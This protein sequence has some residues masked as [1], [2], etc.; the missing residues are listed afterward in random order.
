MKKLFLFIYVVLSAF[1]A[2]C[3]DTLTLR[4]AVEIALANNFSI[5]IAQNDAEIAENNF[6]PGKAGMLP[7]LDA[8]YNQS[9]GVR[10]AQQEFVTG[11]QINREDARTNIINAGVELNWTVFDGFRMFVAYDRLGALQEM[12]ELQAQ[13]AIENTVAAVAIY[14]YEIVQASSR[15]DVL[16]QALKLSEERLDIARERYN[17]GRVA[18]LEVLQ[19]QVDYNADH[20]AYLQQEATMRES[21]IRLNMV[22][23]REPQTPFFVTSTIALS[24]VGVYETLLGNVRGSN[25]MLSLARQEREIASYTYRETGA[26]RYPLLGVTTGYDFTRQRS[27]AGILL[28]NQTN[29]YYYGFTVAVPLFNGFTNRTDLQNARIEMASSDLAYNDAVQQAEAG[30]AVAWSNYI[31]DTAILRIESVNTDLA[32]QAYDLAY[33]TYQYGTITSLELRDVQQNY[34]EAQSRYLEALYRVKLSEIE[35]LRLTGGLMGIR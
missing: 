29:G 19:A 20:S 27:E 28:S 1:N 18:K 35:V 4:E 15:L 21:R 13:L 3:Q 23:A 25:V 31:S 9:V 7:D 22:L 33:E 26:Q 17:V 30:L 5:R 6:T 10:D 11:Q 8:V 34:T 16:G 2:T 24:E 14:Y 12:G 32:R